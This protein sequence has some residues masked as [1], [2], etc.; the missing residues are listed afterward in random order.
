[1]YLDE[2]IAEEYLGAYRRLVVPV[3]RSR[4]LLFGIPVAQPFASGPSLIRSS[5]PESLA[6]NHLF[7]TRVRSASRSRT[8]PLPAGVAK[9]TPE[10]AHELLDENSDET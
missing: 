2:P 3:S 4:R 10:D 8:K 1:M 5:L 7:R 6:V 9:V